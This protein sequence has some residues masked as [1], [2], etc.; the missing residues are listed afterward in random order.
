M[1]NI[2][3]PTLTFPSRSFPA[4]QAGVPAGVAGE[5]LFSEVMPRYSTLVKAQKVF[6]ASAIITAPASF[7]TAAQKGPMLWNRAGSGL[8]AYLLAVSV[9]SPTTANTGGGA[10][11]WV[12]NVQPDAPTSPT[13]IVS[14]NAYAGGGPS[15]MGGVFSTAT[16]GILPTPIFF[17]LTGV[18]TGAVSINAVDHNWTDV[19][20]ALVV[21]PGNVGSICGSAVMTSLVTTIALMWAELPA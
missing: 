12:S 19:G 8:D 16:I 11:G 2:T 18:N 21:G 5:L 13:A 9:S 17:P 4:Q 10:L 1:P 6:Y 3:A 14:W 15:Q 20:G 7:V